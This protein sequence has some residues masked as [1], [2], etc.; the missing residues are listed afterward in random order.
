M[1]GAY[2]EDHG[3]E[4][5]ESDASETSSKD[6]DAIEELDSPSK[7]S[8]GERDRVMDALCDALQSSLTASTHVPS[9]GNS[10]DEATQQ[11]L[12]AL[13][14]QRQQDALRDSSSPLEEYSAPSPGDSFSEGSA[15]PDKTPQKDPPLLGNLD[16]PPTGP[17]FS[18]LLSHP[19]TTANMFGNV[20]PYDANK[21]PAGLLSN[22]DRGFG[23]TWSHGSRGLLGA[24]ERPGTLP[25]TSP[26]GQY[27]DLSPRT[28][29]SGCKTFQEGVFYP[30]VDS[31]QER[32]NLFEWPVQASTDQTKSMPTALYPPKPVFDEIFT[33]D[34]SFFNP[35]GMTPSQ[36]VQ[37]ASPSSPTSSFGKGTSCSGAFTR[38]G[39]E[40]QKFHNQSNP[41]HRSVSAFDPGGSNISSHAAETSKTSEPTVGDQT[42]ASDIQGKYEPDSSLSEASST[43]NFGVETH[44][45]TPKGQSEYLNT[46]EDPITDNPVPAKR[47]F[48]RP[49]F[50]SNPSKTFTSSVYDLGVRPAMSESHDV[51]PRVNSSGEFVTAA[52]HNLALDGTNKTI[53]TESLTSLYE[54]TMS[55]P[56]EHASSTEDIH[57]CIRTIS[58]IDTRMLS[59]K[60]ADEAVFGD[61]LKGDKDLYELLVPLK[62]QKEQARRV[63]RWNKM[64]RNKQRDKLVTRILHSLELFAKH[65]GRQID[66]DSD[67]GSDFDH[68]SGA[69]KKVGGELADE[70]YVEGLLTQLAW[71]N[72]ENRKIKEEAKAEWGEKVKSVQQKVATTHRA[73]LVKKLAK[74]ALDKHTALHQLEDQYA[75]R[76]SDDETKSRL[77]KKATAKIE[78]L[79]ATVRRLER[80]K[81]E[82][83]S[84]KATVA[85]ELEEREIQA[86]DLQGY[87]EAY[88]QIADER[89]QLQAEYY[90]VVA[91][92]DELRQAQGALGDAPDRQDVP[93]SA[94]AT[95]VLQTGSLQSYDNDLNLLENYWTRQ[96]NFAEMAMR[97][98]AAEIR[99]VE[100]QINEAVRQLRLLDAPDNASDAE[101]DATDPE[102]E[103]E[104]EY[105]PSANESLQSQL[106]DT[107][108]NPLHTPKTRPRHLSLQLELLKLVR[109]DQHGRTKLRKPKTATS[110]L[111]S[112]MFT[113]PTMAMESL[114]SDGSIP[115][116]YGGKSHFQDCRQALFS[117]AKFGPW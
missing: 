106:L 86:N 43:A 64:S 33:D 77:H 85:K 58:N 60:N 117:S 45:A 105:Q 13:E 14:G 61:L 16:R 109:R 89:D 49:R 9:K 18:S 97:E 101:S 24:V 70:D 22:R 23:A 91:E 47:S 31:T 111:A 56:D 42:R 112:G 44:S 17:T 59:L 53:L 41:N 54:I 40:F 7:H 19:P 82:L 88:D 96:E 1:V 32:P 95:Y 63:L 67:K 51:V 27:G 68:E 83:I 75:T 114:Q 72:E 107:L 15:S 36:P 37:S 98:T 28:F 115:M 92:R 4:L 20:P 52:L 66:I 6:L 29:S 39:L 93:A 34:I 12:D 74:C 108:T 65:P 35:T 26:V 78:E 99:D 46:P 69:R 57:Q 38:S 94:Q 71:F 102:S 76:I 62:E 30:A 3:D 5:S 10:I 87:R 2:P 110:E 81:S 50:D 73:E 100:A 79:E 113:P 84:A 25:C 80:E 116:N 8:N 48:G 55:F 21:S 11:A 90:D 103:A 104:V